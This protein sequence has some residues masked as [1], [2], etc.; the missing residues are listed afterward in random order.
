MSFFP[1]DDYEN[2]QDDYLED[3]GI[4]IFSDAF[5]KDF[6]E[7]AFDPEIDDDSDEA[8]AER[9]GLTD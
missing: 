2:N 3:D 1:E 8:E 9:Y 6:D 7:I 5:D 4:E